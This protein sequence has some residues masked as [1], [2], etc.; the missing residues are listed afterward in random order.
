M[1]LTSGSSLLYPLANSGSETSI[2]LVSG[3]ATD[4]L[5]LAFFDAIGLL[6]KVNELSC[7]LGWNLMHLSNETS[8]VLIGDVF[9]SFDFSPAINS[10]L[11]IS[12]SCSITVLGGA[13]VSGCLNSVKRLLMS[14]EGCIALL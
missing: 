7:V 1:S 11:C 12:G 4:Y 2:G 9:R 5:K 6:I 3:M 8:I 10:N 14:G 13:I